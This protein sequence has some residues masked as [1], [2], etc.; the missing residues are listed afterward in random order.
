MIAA[1]AALLLPLTAEAQ[2]PKPRATVGAY[3]FD[4]WSGQ[5]NHITELLKNEFA[6]R[7]P[8]WG[9]KV[10]ITRAAGAGDPGSF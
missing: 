8:V 3:Y 9:W 7:K 6:A 4:G 10:E 1:C 5:T 2:Q